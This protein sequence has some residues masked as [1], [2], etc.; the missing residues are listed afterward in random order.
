MLRLIRQWPKAIFWLPQ[1]TLPTEVHH[2]KKFIE[3][4]NIH[5]HWRWK[6]WMKLS[7]WKRKL[8]TPYKGVTFYTVC[9]GFCVI[10]YKYY[11]K[12]LQKDGLYFHKLQR[13]K[14]KCG[15]EINFLLNVLR[16]VYLYVSVQILWMNVGIIL[17]SALRMK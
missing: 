16:G 13:R 11:T 17:W 6:D 2:K 8:L 1:H 12:S 7:S 3:Q 9:L 4:T 14:L 5:N 15:H 10:L